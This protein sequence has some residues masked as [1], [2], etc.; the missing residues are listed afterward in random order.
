MF[1]LNQLF[2]NELFTFPD[3][4]TVT[5]TA[6]CSFSLRHVSVVSSRAAADWF[7]FIDHDRNDGGL[8]LLNKSEMLVR[9]EVRQKEN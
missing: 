7:I 2:Q 5:R 8:I 6:D 3:A 9:K 4:L 1:H